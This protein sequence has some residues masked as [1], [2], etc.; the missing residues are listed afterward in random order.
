MEKQKSSSFFFTIIAIVI[1]SALFKLC[2]F[3]NL[4]INKPALALVY[5][6]TL[7]FTIYMIVKNKKS[8]SES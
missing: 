8:N 5:F 6:I 2:D 7:V 3:K 1:A 4:S